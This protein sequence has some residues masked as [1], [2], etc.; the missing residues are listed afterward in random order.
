[1]WQ[2][3]APSLRAQVRHRRSNLTS[4]NADVV[5]RKHMKRHTRP[6][7]CTFSDCN[8]RHGSRSD[9]KRHEE[10]QHVLHESWKCTM[11]VSDGGNCFADLTS[12][13]ELQSHLTITHD[14]SAKDVTSTFCEQM[15]LGQN[16]SDRFW[17]GFCQG[18]IDQKARIGCDPREMRMQHIGDHFDQ[19]DLSDGSS[20]YSKQGKRRRNVKDESQNG[21][22]S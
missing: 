8:S 11:T 15:R 20:M 10:S 4:V 17:C 16:A 6:Y 12:E 14:L 19:Q 18:I 2:A 21:M 5:H 3:E 7:I 13:V 1:M 22:E 9:W